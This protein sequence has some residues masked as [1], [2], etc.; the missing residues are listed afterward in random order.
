MLE[1]RLSFMLT[2]KAIDRIF[3]T[4]TG[5][6]STVDELNGS[7]ML[8]A[9]LTTVKEGAAEAMQSELDDPILVGARVRRLIDKFLSDP[10][11]RAGDDGWQHVA[12][13]L[14]NVSQIQDGR[15]MLRRRSTR[16]LPRLL[17]E[18]KSPSVV[19]RRGV[20]AALRNCCY[21]TGDHDWLLH[22]VGVVAHLLLPLAG[23]EPLK[24]DELDGM[25]PLLKEALE[26]LGERKV[27]EADDETKMS[28][29]S[30][31]HLLCTSKNSRQ[32]LRRFRAYPIIRNFDLAETSEPIK[33]VV[34]NIVQFLI[35]DEQEGDNE[36]VYGKCPDE[37]KA[38]SDD[39]P[40]SRSGAAEQ[41]DFLMK[42][43]ILDADAGSEM[44]SVD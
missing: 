26:S 2:N 9:N 16:I 36:S 20:S 41:A 17:V 18:L 12:S 39:L 6:E 22:E 29:C 30:A 23:P 4:L 42:R 11:G 14:C 3:A 28:L 24:I 25:E 33:E 7:L 37:E 10:S 8:L 1:E 21:E 19:R 44:N 34:Y 27:R 35:T 40:A 32:Y 31:L 13:L 38:V 15:D 43:D 5:S